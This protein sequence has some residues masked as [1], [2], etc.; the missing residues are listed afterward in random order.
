MRDYIRF[1]CLG[2]IPYG[3]EPG[4]CDDEQ[5]GK[6]GGKRRHSEETPTTLRLDRGR[7]NRHV[8]L[9]GRFVQID[10]RGKDGTAYVAIRG[11][12]NKVRTSRRRKSTVEER[13]ELVSIRVLSRRHRTTALGT[14]A[15]APQQAVHLLV[16]FVLHYQKLIPPSA[17]T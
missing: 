15:K 3:D 11:V 4:E 7:S 16:E 9:N 17:R 13:G 12:C 5:A 1:V 10:R 2:E 6:S 8:R 14:A